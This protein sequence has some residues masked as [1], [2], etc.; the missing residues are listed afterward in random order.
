LYANRKGWPLEGIDVTADVKRINAAD[1]PQYTGSA[2][3]VH[4]Y[5]EQVVLHG[6]LSDEQKARLMEIASKCPVRRAIGSP[7]F[8]VEELLEAEALPGE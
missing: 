1:Y 3:F 7:T 8:F 6:P 4:E 2:P 5:R